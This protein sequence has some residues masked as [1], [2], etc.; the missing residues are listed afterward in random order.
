MAEIISLS[1]VSVPS[2]YSDT[3][4]VRYIG[5]V[6]KPRL[7][8][9]LL[10]RAFRNVN[11]GVG[12]LNA[13]G[14]NIQFD[15][16]ILTNADEEVEE[17]YQIVQTFGP[18]FLF[19]YGPKPRIFTYSGVLFNT[20]EKPWTTDWQWAWDNSVPAQP[21]TGFSPIQGSTQRGILSGTNTILNGG[22]A[23]LEYDGSFGYQ[24]SGVI[25]PSSIAGGSIVGSDTR[26][27]LCVREGY[28]IKMSIR[29]SGDRPNAASFQLVMLVTN[30]LDF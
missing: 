18:D 10:I 19:L 1:S 23:R 14:A 28:I 5:L 13:A 6:N 11:L 4:D 21:G 7:H 12:G 26:N 30:R 15:N 24:V 8:P 9:R 25:N 16:F 29:K 20:T 3:A 2:Q 22:I 17:K 27:T